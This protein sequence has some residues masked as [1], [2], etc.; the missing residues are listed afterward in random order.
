MKYNLQEEAKKALDEA[1]AWF[2]AEPGRQVPCQFVLHKGANEP[3]HLELG[4][5]DGEEKS[6]KLGVLKH[7][8]QKTGVE[9]YL[10]ISEAWVAHV[11]GDNDPL[12]KVMPRD[13]EDRGEVIH[14]SAN[15]ALESVVMSAEIVR[16]AD[17][18]VSTKPY[19]VMDGCSYGGRMV[20]LLR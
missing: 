3:L 19:T 17:G 5:A 8:M 9:W 4:W 14:V 16:H 20:E 11:N 13:R 12:R 6:F 1:C 2:C 18:S 15:D 10:H 7:L